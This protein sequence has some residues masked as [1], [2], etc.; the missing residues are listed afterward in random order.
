MSNF[1]FAELTD[2]KKHPELVAQNRLDA[3]KF[4]PQIEANI[5]N[6]EVLRSILNVK[7]KVTSG[8]R[9]LA[10]NT[11]VGGSKTSSHTKGLATDFVP[12]GMSV[13][14]A[15]NIL[16]E[17]REKCT[18][19]NRLII[20]KIGGVEWLHAQAKFVITEETKFFSTVDGKNFKEEK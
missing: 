2:S 4:L 17:N 10:L 19:L 3:V 20:E 13:Q 16:L 5:R 6:L 8:F 12:L 18:W 9:N 11:A 14:E 15:F 1:T 7:M